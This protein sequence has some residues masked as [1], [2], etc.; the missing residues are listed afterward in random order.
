MK[1]GIRFNT[2]F[3]LVLF[4]LKSCNVLDWSWWLIA[5]PIW[6]P[7]VF[8]EILLSIYG[9]ITILKEKKEED[10]RKKTA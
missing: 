6:I 9:A 7:I 8:L 3:F 4:I 10:A 5:G 2:L 1:N